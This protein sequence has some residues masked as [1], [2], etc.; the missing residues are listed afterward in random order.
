V[1]EEYVE[2]ETR[3]DDLARLVDNHPSFDQSAGE[4][5]LVGSPRMLA[6]KADL[7]TWLRQAETAR[8]VALR[9][10]AELLD[11][12]RREALPV[13]LAVRSPGVVQRFSGLMHDVSEAG[14]TIVVEA[15]WV[16]VCVTSTGIAEAWVVRTPSLD[17]PATSL[18]LLDA[19]ARVFLSVS[20]ARWPGKPEPAPW[21][22]LLERLKTA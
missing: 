13:S 8:P 15:P 2:T 6:A 4:Q 5:I 10:L 7:S 14:T 1:H 11:D 21:C 3:R 20:A 18:E 16:R 19:S 9:S 12:V 17:G 22:E